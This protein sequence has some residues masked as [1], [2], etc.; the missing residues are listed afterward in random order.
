M[1]RAM[2]SFALA[3]RKRGNRDDARAGTSLVQPLPQEL[4]L[5]R[6]AKRG[7][8][9][10]LVLDTKSLGERLKAYRKAWL[11]ARGC[12]RAKGWIDAYMKEE[13]P[14]IIGAT[15]ARE[16]QRLKKLE[17]KE[18][19]LSAALS[20]PA[21]KVLTKVQASRR[22]RMG[23]PG[24]CFILPELHQELW[25]FF[26]DTID[27]V[28]GRLPAW[29]LL[30]KARQITAELRRLHQ[31]RIHKGE[32]PA[33]P[34]RAP[35]LDY[36][37]LLRW[38]AAYHVSWRTVNLR[39][40][41]PMA[42]L[43]QRVHQF[44]CNVLRLRWMLVH[45]YGSE[46]GWLW[47][48][49]DQKPLWLTSASAHRTLAHSGVDKV[50]VKENMA[51]TRNIF[52]VMTRTA[53]PRLPADGK[54]MA[55]LFRAKK[56]TTI[57]KA[58]RV[59][60][61]VFLQFA[62]NGSYQLEH[63]KEFYKWLLPSTREEKIRFCFSEPVDPIPEF[64]EG[65]EADHYGFIVLSDWFAP[66]LNADVTGMIEDR[67]GMHLNIPGLCT[68]LVQTNDTHCHGPYSAIYKRMETEENN[69]QLDEGVG[70]PAVDRQTVLDRAVGAWKQ[71][72][73]D[74]VSHG[75]IGNG[76]SNDLNGTEDNQLT[77]EA[78]E[79]WQRL[80]MQSERLRLSAEV[81]E[82]VESG[83]V[84]SWKDYK[85]VLVAYDWHAP[86]KEGEETI[87]YVPV[88]GYKTEGVATDRRE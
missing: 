1:G 12:K 24:R 82:L 20:Q 70:L 31:A 28:K 66:N 14:D 16:K 33:D 80:D 23:V 76:I 77:K 25:N 58:L 48:N 59:P 11:S 83:A 42:V 35:K 4:A 87:S 84:Q 27:N 47:V 34:F 72:A 51:A 64:Q 17:G 63:T 8:R 21:S 30:A 61:S 10:F 39:F 71:V 55:I 57:R 38:R 15:R 41:C 5:A 49:C 69:E 62:P 65:A 7:R 67:G 29:Y 32:I 79:L 26:V 60:E 81:L 73:H 19:R 88:E 22:K 3:V 43:L 40:K 2:D 6:G 53:Y 45:L 36:A 9:S 68:G 46:H 37:W 86:M 54:D 74:R 75:F 18:R 50:A 85:K 52:T 44:W 56:G 78:A 13:C